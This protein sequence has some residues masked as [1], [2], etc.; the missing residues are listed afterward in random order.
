MFGKRF[1]FIHGWVEGIQINPSGDECLLMLR[2]DNTQTI[3]LSASRPDWHMEAGNEISAAVKNSNPSHAVALIDH[4]AGDGAILPCTERRT[5]WEDA[6]ITVALLGLTLFLSGWNALPVFALLVA[7]YG[8]TRYVFPEK[9]RRRDTA[10]IGYLIDE[11]YRRWRQARDGKK[12][13]AGLK[14]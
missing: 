1:G 10:K 8:L 5:S 11:D 6:V 2:Q 12:S 4:T 7:L 13:Q 14:R 3:L 9:I